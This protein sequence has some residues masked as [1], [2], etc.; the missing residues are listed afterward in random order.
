MRVPRRPHDVN[1]SIPLPSPGAILNCVHTQE[2]CEIIAKCKN[3]KVVS[4]LRKKQEIKTNRNNNKLF[5]VK[6]MC[7]MMTN[8]N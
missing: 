8:F 6:D 7:N 3:I 1:P 4:M 2:N 5:A